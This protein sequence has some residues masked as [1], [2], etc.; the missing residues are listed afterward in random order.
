MSNI[1]RI[2]ANFKVF[3]QKLRHVWEEYNLVEYYAPFLHEKIKKGEVEPFK[4]VPF[5]ADERNLWETSRSKSIAV[6]GQGIG[7]RHELMSCLTGIEGQA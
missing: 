3:R 5:L 4:F 6:L 7:V 2:H 1:K